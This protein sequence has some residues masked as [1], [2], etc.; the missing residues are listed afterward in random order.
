MVTQS[1]TAATDT[2]SV[3]RGVTEF[4]GPYTYTLVN[5]LTN[6]PGCLNWDDTTLDLTLV[7]S[8]M[9]DVETVTDTEIIVC[10]QRYPTICE[11]SSPFTTEIV[12][13][14]SITTISWTH[15]ADI[16]VNVWYPMESE[17]LAPATDSASDDAIAAG[18]STGEFC[19]PYTY[20]LTNTLTNCPGCLVW[21]DSSLTLTL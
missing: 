19:G 5:T 12:D 10:L 18:T 3:A 1:F 8:N 2:E 17:V 20:T 21:D 9:A 15:P 13:P 6:C 14:C 11:T 16:A 7:S 4:C